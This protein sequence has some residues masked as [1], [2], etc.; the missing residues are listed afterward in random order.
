MTEWH[1]SAIRPP[2]LC[3]RM[4]VVLASVN[5]VNT[6]EGPP[7]CSSLWGDIYRSFLVPK[8]RTPLPTLSSR[9][10]KRAQVVY[11]HPSTSRVLPTCRCP[12]GSQ[13]SQEWLHIQIIVIDK[14]V[15]ECFHSML[16]PSTTERHIVL[17]PDL[18]ATF[19]F[20]EGVITLQRGEKKRHKVAILPYL[21]HR[22]RWQ[23]RMERRTS[24]GW[25]LCHRSAG[26]E[27][28]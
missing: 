3:G 5:L 27:S 23:T 11:R 18:E 17:I 1:I 22:A 14:E 19:F 12:A 25:G 15:P 6:I 10:G 21:E 20:F 28:N 7:P 9:I 2:Y 16:L 26:S 4:P 8:W 13:C 24:P